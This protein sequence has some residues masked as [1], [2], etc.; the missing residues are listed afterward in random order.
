M[1]LR[2]LVGDDHRHGH[3]RRVPA[4]GRNPAEEGLRR[5]LVRQVEGLRIVAR[6]KGDDLLARD[7][8]AAEG[9]DRAFDEILEELFGDQVRH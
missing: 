4:A 3:R 9:L 5:R 1:S 6:G 7:F 8:G 2:L